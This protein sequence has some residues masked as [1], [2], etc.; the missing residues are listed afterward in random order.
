LGTKAVALGSL[1]GNF[2]DVKKDSGLWRGSLN[3]RYPR[4]QISNS[5]SSAE[6]ARRSRG[7]FCPK[8]I[9]IVRNGLDLQRFSVLNGNVV[10]KSYIVGIGSLLSY[11]RWDRVLRILCE[12]KR[13]GIEC[14]LRI[15][16]D[17][18]ERRPLERQAQD[19]DIS[20]YVEFLGAT[21]DI[22]GLL[23]QS[24]FLVHTSDTEGCPNAV[25]EAIA[26]GRP[27][28]AMD[29][30][31]IPFLVEDGTNGFV[32]RRGDET[33]FAERVFQLLADDELCRR[34]G[35]AARAKAEQEFGLESLVQTTL[36][37][38]KVAGWR[39]T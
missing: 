35:L 17:G 13:R 23:E 14:R 15:A 38:Y 19:L 29:A 4:F 9:N 2:D 39:N 18:P 34:M 37:A 32:I 21:L 5:Y 33:T 22:P 25:M 31:D 26:C 8:H 30:G 27:V 3:A 36:D 28:V 1:R 11:K 10:I 24:R 7:I 16:G 20:E 6:R 12:V